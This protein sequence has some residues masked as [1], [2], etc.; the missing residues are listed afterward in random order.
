M[1]TAALLTV[2]SLMGASAFV[3]PAPKFSRTRGVARMSFEDEAGVTAPL[4]Y[5][6]SLMKHVRF[7]NVHVTLKPVHPPSPP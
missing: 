3:A 2:S 7:R 1:K 6:V 5:W 4:G